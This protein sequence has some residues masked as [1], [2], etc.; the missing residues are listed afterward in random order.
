MA[1]LLFSVYSACVCVCVCECACV[2][3]P[4]EQFPLMRKARRRFLGDAMKYLEGSSA[5]TNKL[6]MFTAQKFLEAGLIRVGICTC[7]C[8]CVYMCV[9]KYKG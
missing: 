2:G 8:V 1:Y 9:C 5:R 4:A 6:L 7:M 3:V